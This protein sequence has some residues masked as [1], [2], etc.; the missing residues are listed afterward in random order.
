MSLEIISFEEKERWDDVV[1]SFSNFDVYYL[2]SYAKAF[3]LHGDGEPVLFYFTG[4]EGRAINVSMKRDIADDCHFTGLLPKQTFYD[5]ITPYGYGGYLV[6][7]HCTEEL[8]E[9]YTQYCRENGIV[10]E[11][12]RFHPVLNNAKEME[13]MYEVITLGNTVCMDLKDNIWENCTS[14][15]RNMIRKAVKSGLKVYWS[16]QPSDISEF[17][18]IYNATMD[19]DAATPYY[20]FK[21][22]FYNSILEDLNRNALFF[23]CMLNEKTVAMS[24]MLFA[25]KHMHYHLSGSLPEYRSLAPTNLLLYEAAEYGKE[26][27]YE[28][29]HLGG[30]L[31]SAKDHLYSFKKAFNRKEDCT[32]CIG[33]RIYDNEK[34]DMLMKLRENDPTVRTDFFP[35]Y[36]S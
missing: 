21:S 20:Y 36:R 4:K 13:N 26:N 14:K 8:K 33:K 10:S 19:R 24:I 29:F 16:R 3:M 6:E 1:R 2:N 11:F 28:T 7:G 27:G 18:N 35:V 34:Y 9:A 22:D 30:G 25:N 32:F 5:L 12:V 31:G 15:N 17:M 23:R